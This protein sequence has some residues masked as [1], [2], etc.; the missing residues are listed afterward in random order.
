MTFPNLISPEELWRDYVSLCNIYS[1]FRFASV[2]ACDREVSKQ[3]L[4]HVLVE[5]SRGILHNGSIQRE[6]RDELFQRDS[7][8]LAHMAILVGG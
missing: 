8:T 5:A 2:C 4:F 3:R 7:A 6:L 1:F